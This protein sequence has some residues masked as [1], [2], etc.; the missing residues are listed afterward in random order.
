MCSLSAMIT[1]L[2][3][4][5]CRLIINENVAKALEA[6]NG[7]K[8]LG[9]TNLIYCLNTL[10]SSV[11]QTEGNQNHFFLLTD[12][13]VWDV[14]ECW[15]VIKKSEN[16]ILNVFGIGDGAST[17]S[18]AKLA[19]VGKG[20]HYFI[21]DKWSK[22]KSK[23]INLLSNNFEPKII[24]EKAGWGIAGKTVCEYPT[25]HQIPSEMTHGSYFTSFLIKDCKRKGLKGFISF[26]IKEKEGEAEIEYDYIL[27]E[28]VV[29]IEGDFLFKMGCDRYIKGNNKCTLTKKKITDLSL[30]YGISGDYTSFVI[31]EGL[32][33]DQIA[34]PKNRVVHYPN[35][36]FTYLRGIPIPAK[37]GSLLKGLSG[38]IPESSILPG[39]S[40]TVLISIRTHTDEMYWLK[41][42]L[43]MTLLQVKTLFCY[44]HN[45]NPDKFKLSY[46]GYSCNGTQTLESLGVSRSDHFVLI[47]CL[48]G[49]GGGIRP[50][51]K[52][53]LSNNLYK[54]IA[55]DPYDNKHDFDVKLDIACDDFIKVVAEKFFK[56]NTNCFYLEFEGQKLHGWL[57]L[58]LN[59]VREGWEIKIISIMPIIVELQC[60]DGSFNSTISKL[61][62]F[63]E[64]MLFDYAPQILKDFGSEAKTLSFIYTWIGLY[65]IKKKLYNH[66]EELSLISEK[67]EMFLDKVSK[68][69]VEY[70]D[71][72]IITLFKLKY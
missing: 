15:E 40:E 14:E 13:E 46:R 21:N 28:D 45:Y 49:G 71:I 35:T 52:A 42:S 33:T 19:Q 38:K 67:A 47:P 11:D 24:I 72:N 39:N 55:I 34:I 8:A 5:R 2:Y 20:K 58:Y 48:S 17:D 53:M 37:E 44:N 36:E 65:I 30:K 29:I 1:A 43:S 16:W 50:E 69:T 25:Q 27:P 4:Q 54:V 22:L 31:A 56:K 59:E 66:K 7:L 60:Y 3:S 12:G 57:S 41:V 64:K 6:V 68:G 32:A 10:Y 26:A 63:E 51:E 61:V 18:V 70:D 23:A 9:G 62:D